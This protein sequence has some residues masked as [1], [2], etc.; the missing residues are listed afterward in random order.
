MPAALNAGYQLAFLIGAACAAIA[1]AL[2]LLLRP[3]SQQTE[4][5]GTPA[6][7]EAE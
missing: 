1:G 3:A 2:A 5:A 6:P 7:A 4:A